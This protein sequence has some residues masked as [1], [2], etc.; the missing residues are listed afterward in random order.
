MTV[1]KRKT[2]W[3][4]ALDDWTYHDRESSS[5]RLNCVHV[6][7]THLDKMS[8]FSPNTS[9]TLLSQSLGS[10]RLKWR[11]YRR[12][13]WVWRGKNK[14]SI[15]MRRVIGRRWKITWQRRAEIESVSKHTL[16]LKPSR[17]FIIHIHSRWW[18]CF[19]TLSIVSLL[20]KLELTKP[21][22]L[23]SIVPPHSMSSK[24]AEG[25]GRRQKARVWISI[26]W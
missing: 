24:S 6:R 23:S 12:I 7:T 3:S 4:G 22:L 25:V 11:K 13:Y 8:V 19:W 14:V 20:M 18:L 10:L 9:T 15:Q 17:T 16:T 2:W 5:S 26:S 1:I 21:S